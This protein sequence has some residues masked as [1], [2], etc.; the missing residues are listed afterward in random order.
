MKKLVMV[1][2]VFASIVTL[3]G[4]KKQQGVTD[5]EIIV[6]NAAAVSGAFATVGL[7]FNQGI[8]AYFAMI[9]E[10]GGVNGRTIK[11]MN[12]D[13]GFDPAT[14]IINTEQLVEDEQ[15]FALVGHFG[16]PTVGATIDYLREAGIPQVYFATGISALY[17][18]KA[19]GNDRSSFPVQPIYDSEGQVMVARAVGDFNATKIGVIY[20]NDDAG[21]G[22]LSGVRKQA[23]EEGVTLVEAQV[24]AD[25]TDMSAAALTIVDGDVDF[26]IVAANQTPASVAIKAL[27]SAGNTADAIVSYVNAA[28]SFIQSIATDLANFDVYASAWINI[29]KEDG[30][31]TD[32]YTLFATE[33]SKIDAALAAN[34]YAMA[35]WVA[36]AFF[37]EGLERVGEDDLTWENYINAMEESPVKNPLGGTIDYS[38]GQRVGT[39]TMSLLKATVIPATETTVESYMFVPFKDMESIDDILK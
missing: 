16:T 31:F 22:I 39:Q 1:L 34:P 2:L 36:A 27:S 10:D 9:N 30:T 38:N 33:V 11:F 29:F 26:V 17:N 37:V 28:P 4:C 6:G 20:T 18:E 13:D 35:G 8:E 23:T 32:E 24:A 25:A 21:N 15:V 3:T 19:E 14:G 7:P 5:T 12:L